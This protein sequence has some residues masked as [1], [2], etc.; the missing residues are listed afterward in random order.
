MSSVKQWRAVAT[1]AVVAGI[2]VYVPSVL[3]QSP[4]SNAEL[5]R[6]VHQ[7]AAQ[8]KRLNQRLDAMQTGQPPE[9]GQPAAFAPATGNRN[10]QAD[11]KKTASMQKEI[12]QLKN[13]GVKVDW[14]SGAPDFSSP[15]GQ[16][17][18][19]LHGRIQYDFSSTY[20]SRFKGNND[21][22][23]RNIT[24]TEFRRIRL[25]AEG[26][27]GSVGG[28]PILYKSEIDFAGDSTGIRD[29]YLS[30]KKKFQLGQGVVYLGSKFA[31]TG[32]DGRT[33]SKWIWFTERNTVANGIGAAPGAY[34]VGAEG[35]F[36]GNNDWHYS[37]AVTKGSTSDSNDS[38]DNLLVR[39]RAHWDPINTG[40]TILHV[41]V[42]GYYQNLN[43]D[44]QDVYSDNTSIGGHY[45]GNLRIE[46][47]TVNANTSTAYGFELA[48]LTGPLAAGAEYARRQVNGRNDNPNLDYYA[49]SGQVGYSIT[50][51]QFG[52][53]TK[54]GT[55]T[56]PD[57]AH[58]IDQGGWGAW[59]IMA[60]YEAINFNDDGSY[61]GG[62][63]HGTTLGLSWYPN[64]YVR[65]LLDV[66]N[67]QTN[68]RVPLAGGV[69]PAS[70]YYGADD[71]YSINARA[72]V[73]F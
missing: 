19:G 66:T 49:Y 55:W 50:G 3:A 6:L 30:T 23:S 38:S 35:E 26:Q 7:Q 62:T 14:S 47:P 12:D 8:I 53:S 56:H 67:W 9:S 33:S 17:S 34:N 46:S 54:Q 27:L 11:N 68:N 10:R 13:N 21:L 65:G 37:L 36:Y 18:F 59:Q 15:D 51:E 24:G 72:Q 29:M 16:F 71:G 48:G 25:D 41:G 57:V 70:D 45:N 32:L 61:A 31:D 69:D 60:R 52:Y 4:P 2:S 28:M 40:S 44:R 43:Q 63:G 22:N 42:N 73:V 20:G 58:P 1:T 39:S 5:M 64:A